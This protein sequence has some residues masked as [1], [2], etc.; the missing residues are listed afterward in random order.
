MGFALQTDDI[1]WSRV[2]TRTTCH[3]F[4]V[5]GSRD[6]PAAKGH[7][8]QFSHGMFPECC[9]LTNEPLYKCCVCLIRIE[10]KERLYSAS[11]GGFCVLAFT[12]NI[13]PNVGQICRLNGLRPQLP[14]N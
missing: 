5:I 2:E 3:L 1:T 8:S 14:P 7:G 12:A 11:C 10:A 9:R 6:L 13:I 4:E